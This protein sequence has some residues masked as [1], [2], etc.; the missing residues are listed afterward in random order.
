MI[1]KN[2]TSEHIIKAIEQIRKNGIPK[3]RKSKKFLLEFNG[4]YY[5][6]KYVISLANKYANGEILDPSRFSGGKETNDF[7]RKLGF[8]II[9]VPAQEKATKSPKM[10]KERKLPNIH[11]GERCPRCKET[12]KRLLEKIYGRVEENYK[13]NVGTCP[14]NFKGRSYYNKLREIYEALQS[15]RGSK[16]F[17][18]A[19]TLPNCDF[20]IP[21][22]GFIVEFDESQHFT[23][24]RKIAL[25]KYPSNLELGFNREKWIRLCEKINAK[26]NDP[27]YRDEQRAWYDTLRDFS[28]IILG[29]KP[30][31]RL[32]AKDF[33]WCQLDPENPR[34]V[35]K[36][37]RIIEKE[38]VNRQLEV[39]K[40]LLCTP[41]YSSNTEINKFEE[42]I[43]KFSNKEKVHLVIFPEAYIKGVKFQN[44]LKEV[45][46]RF[47]NLNSPVL[48][49]VET[50]EGYQ[51]AVFYNP[52]P[53]PNETEK[54]IYLKH[55][56]AKKLA[57]EYKEYK[58]KHDKMFDPIILKGKKFGVMVCHDMFFSLIPHTL[59]KHG[60]EILIDLTGGNVNFQKWRNIIKARSIEF[61][62]TFLCTMGY[63]PKKKQRSYCFA[64]HY[65]KIIPI[66]C[67]NNKRRI[68]ITNFRDL[69][70]KPPYFCLIS[71]P[72]LPDE[73]IKDD[74]EY[75]Y[76]DIY[77]SDVT[78]SIATGNK[79]DIEIMGD[80][81]KPEFYTHGQRLS[82]DNHWVKVELGK[83]L[84]GLLLLSV[85][86]IKDSTL[87]L[88]HVKRI[89]EKRE[90]IHY[91]IVLY[92][93]KDSK[94]SR[95][96]L[97][98]LAKL[99]AIENRVGV[100][101][102]TDKI[103]L[104]LEATRYKQIQLFKERNGI[105][106]LTKE[107]LKGPE[108]IFTRNTQGIHVKFKNIYLELL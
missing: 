26:D 85:K 28:S 78:I 42:E 22:P 44:V 8:N 90:K 11:N 93:G 95:S 57:Y 81:E 1:P 107:Y 32:Y 18:K 19:K 103:K 27:P 37:R 67:F 52:Y 106:G 58:G 48:T 75:K 71:I 79:A 35:E 62:N 17:V 105:F 68:K 84:I 108:N 74:E 102:F 101:V 82:V 70:Q 31:V 55:S 2:I 33:V 92:H 38:H 41:S 9:S 50:E 63:N 87:V 89:K 100:I 64:Y 47:K 4:A 24:P 86:N 88:K 49:G 83:E 66:D 45:K 91:Y 61:G 43:I 60:A 80:A 51:V 30:T 13:F 94:F 20:F 99:R 3:N 65:G 14:E 12:I 54:H 56:T 10:K 21:N 40:L 5:P 25:E 29:L 104:V 34:D 39:I 97:L 53:Q 96:E 6:P 98:S 72:P 15:Y 16:E 77:Y 46:M 76:S 36:F 73:L 23:L 7:L 69:P 59:V